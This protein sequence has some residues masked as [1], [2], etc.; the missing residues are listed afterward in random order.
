MFLEEEFKVVVI[1]VGMEIFEFFGN[2]IIDIGGGIVDVVV[3]F[4]GDIVI[5]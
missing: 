1:G 2:M 4:M 3:L 5:S